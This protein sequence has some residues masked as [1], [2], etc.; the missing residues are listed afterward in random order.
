MRSTTTKNTDQSEQLGAT[1]SGSTLEVARRVIEL[2]GEAIAALLERLDNSFEALV[3]QI[4]SSKGRVILS[5]VGKSGL[6]AKKIA[7]TLTGTGTAAFFVHPVDA[8][9]GD[10]G[11]ID[12]SD[13]ALLISKSGATEELAALFPTFK[14][15]GVK[16]AC[17]TAQ[18]ESQ[19]AKASD[20][21]VTFGLVKEA[22]PFNFT[23]TSS[24]TAC[25]V[26]GDALAI[27]LLTRR[28]FKRDDFAYLHPGGVLGRTGLMRVSEVMHTGNELPVVKDQTTMNDVIVEIIN[29]RLG[30]ATVV[31]EEG[32]L[33][34]IVTDGDLKRIL[35]ERATILDLKV[36]DVM[37][38]S[39]KL[40]NKND[41]VASAVEK[42]E[43]NPSGP[44]TALI[45]VDGEGKPEGVVHLHDC[46]RSQNK[47][48]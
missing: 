48:R 24:T 46:L 17:I 26:L 38:P 28:G 43:S 8:M 5:G 33:V 16:V 7:A 21:A 19:L 29:K 23:P 47:D 12:P 37:T 34:G 25:L 10:L 4:L 14:R 6:V 35:H 41:L 15:L 18:S 1:R 13:T 42:M 11:I 3:N 20:V 9:H 40:V 45:V 32:V 44:I 31:N 27:A 2:E 30:L 39:P 22:C 36:A